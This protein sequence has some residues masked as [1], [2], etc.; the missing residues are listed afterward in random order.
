MNSGNDLESDASDFQSKVKA[1]KKL[2]NNVGG[3]DENKK[4]RRERL[5]RT[6]CSCSATL[7]SPPPPIG[8]PI[9]GLLRGHPVRAFKGKVTE[10]YNPNSAIAIGSGW[11]ERSVFPNASK[12]F[13]HVDSSGNPSDRQLPRRAGFASP[14]PGA[15][16]LSSAKPRVTPRVLSFWRPNERLQVHG[17]GSRIEEKW[18]H[19]AALRAPAATPPPLP[20]LRPRIDPSCLVFRVRG[21]YGGWIMDSLR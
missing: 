5:P 2:S 3:G 18:G 13:L 20:L 1:V 10:N 21:V 8:H 4:R 16:S 19:T 17:T 12:G 9:P 15:S 7:R 14:P 11:W 6:S